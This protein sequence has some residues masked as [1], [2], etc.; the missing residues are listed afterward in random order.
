[1]LA[2]ELFSWPVSSGHLLNFLIHKVE[3]KYLT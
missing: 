1:M 3:V 2:L